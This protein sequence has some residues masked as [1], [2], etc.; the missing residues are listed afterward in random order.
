MNNKTFTE[1]ELHPMNGILA[2]FLW[3]LGE[4][5]STVAFVFG[6]IFTE[7]GISPVLGGIMVGAGIVGWIIFSILFGGL[8]TVQPNEARVM[9]LFGKYYGTVKESGFYFVNP[10]SVS[11][12]PK[13]NTPSSAHHNAYGG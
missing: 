7:E 5:A 4:I 8:R 9:T 10:F 11:V 3:I 1:K 6:I 2:L 13:S 12:C